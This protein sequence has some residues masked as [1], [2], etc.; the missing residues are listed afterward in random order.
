M[1]Y[2]IEDA[3]CLRETDDALL[4]YSPDTGDEWFPKAVIREESEIA[5]EGDAGELVICTWWARKQGWL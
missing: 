3:E 2:S 5:G 4:I 1:P